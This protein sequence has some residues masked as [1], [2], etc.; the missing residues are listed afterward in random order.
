MAQVPSQRGLSGLGV[1]A[2]LPPFPKCPVM[3]PRDEMAPGP[4]FCLVPR[5][6]AATPW[7]SK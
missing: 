2:P 4:V 7:V 6:A 5:K 1:L 3:A